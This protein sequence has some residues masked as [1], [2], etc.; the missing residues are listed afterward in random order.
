MDVADLRKQVMFDLKIQ[1]AQ[2]PCDDPAA[3]RKIGS[4]QHLMFGPGVR[5]AAAFIGGQGE[6][7]QGGVVRQLKYD[8]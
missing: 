3:A 4:R 6:I 1:A 8:R 7:D 5:H 2:Q